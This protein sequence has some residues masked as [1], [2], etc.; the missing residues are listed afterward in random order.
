MIH[1]F[2]A[3]SMLGGLKI[4][5]GRRWSISERIVISNLVTARSIVKDELIY[6]GLFS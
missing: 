2:F 5:Y 3:E 4:R 6:T 1:V